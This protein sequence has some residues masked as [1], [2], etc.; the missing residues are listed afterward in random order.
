MFFSEL[1][2]SVNPSK[3]VPFFI[4]FEMNSHCSLSEEDEECDGILKQALEV[5]ISADFNPN[6]MPR[7]G[8]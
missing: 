7:D 6:S 3:Q 8:K 1:R 2:I 4:N 5:K